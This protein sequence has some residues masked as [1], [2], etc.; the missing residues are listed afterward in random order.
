[1]AKRSKKRAIPR[2]YSLVRF[3]F[4]AFDSAHLVHYPFM[5]D[6]VYVFLGEIAQMPGHCV[7]AD[8]QGISGQVYAGWHT[9]LFIELTDDET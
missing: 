8:Y 3:D 4:D 6:R 7:L 5:K 9:D 1:M 2:P